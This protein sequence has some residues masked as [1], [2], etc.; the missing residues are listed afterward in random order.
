MPAYKQIYKGVREGKEQIAYM[1]VDKCVIIVS[2][3]MLLVVGMLYPEMKAFAANNTDIQQTDDFQITV[4]CGIDGI[5]AYDYPTMVQ[6]TVE[7]KYDFAGALRIM[8]ENNSSYSK[9]VAYGEDISLTANQAKT[10]TF[11]MIHPGD[12]S[13]LKVEL[14]NE[15]G[16]RV[17][18]QSHYFKLTSDGTGTG[19]STWV[20]ILSDDYNALNYFDGIRLVLNN[21]QY[22]TGTLELTKDSFPADSG[23]LSI[24]HYMIIDNFDTG[25]LTDEQYTALKDWVNNGGVL[26]LALGSNYQ[27]VLHCFS[28]DFV[29]GTIGSLGKKDLPGLSLSGVDCLDFQLEAGIEMIGFSTDHTAYYRNIGLGRVVVLAYSLGME[30]LVGY[31]GNSVIGQNLMTAAATS[32]TSQGLNNSYSGRD[33]NG[34]ELA[35]LADTTRKPSVLL[36]GFILLLYV[37]LVGPILY[38]I[39]KAMKKRE[40]IWTAIPVVVLAFTGV[41]FLTGLLYRVNKPLVNTFSLITLEEGHKTEKIYTSIT[42]P[43]AKQ[44]TVAVQPEYGNIQYNSSGYNYSLFDTGTSDYPFDYMIKRTGEGTELVLNNTSTFNETTFNVQRTEENDIGHIECDLKCYTTG[45][46]GTVTNQ[47]GYDLTGVVV[48]FERY[49]YQV[50]DL[51]RGEQAVI[52]QS[53]LIMSTG[54]GAFLSLY[55]NMPRRYS[56]EKLYMQSQI[57]MMMED[58]YV[59]ETSYGQGCVWAKISSYAP[60]F[61]GKSNVKQSGIGLIY[62]TFQDD[63]EDVGAAYYP[64]LDGMVVIMDGYLNEDRG[65]FNVPEPITITYSFEGYPGITT[66]EDVNFAERGANNTGTG[67]YYADV[68]ALNL[69]T[70]EF[71]QIF[72]DSAIL[73]GADLNKYMVDNM[74]VLKYELVNDDVYGTYL[75]RIIAR[76]DE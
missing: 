20:G 21:N 6:V 38:L 19:A 2:W 14:L 53:K 26:I 22:I 27:N 46:E 25:N 32:V 61:I 58:Y 37:V 39:L 4:K 75:P 44:Y 76:G 13:Y 56:D 30:P 69:Q 62:E 23:A 40:K 50:G 24:L 36:Y 60:D 33:Y 16:N 55:N 31:S 42:C 65:S 47:T 15:K 48:N 29:T 10:F 74:L 68:Y 43:K 41:I 73:S 57:D 72:V 66:L 49:Y 52:D 70:G 64:S 45:F 11:Y 63:Y 7:S 8:P 67:K 17:Y 12:S 1:K 59:D 18:E 51:K 71:E 3:I 54:G 35:R 34:I 5:A 9:V 28:D